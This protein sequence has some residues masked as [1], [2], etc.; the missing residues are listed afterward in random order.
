MPKQLSFWGN[1]ADGDCVSAEEAFAKSCN[2]PEIFILESEVITWA[3][4]HGLLNGAYLNQVMELMQS[5]GFAQGG[6]IYD[7]G[8]FLSVNWTD[9]TTLQGA[10]S[11][12]PVKIGVAG[13]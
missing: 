9:S 1:Y 4:N 5:D 11:Q 6:L 3:T 12:G 2:N 13:D 10:I 8:P 7:D